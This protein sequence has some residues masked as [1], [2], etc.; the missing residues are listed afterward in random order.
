MVRQTE[1]SGFYSV[2]RERPAVVPESEVV[3]CLI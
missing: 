3:R 1:E 2:G